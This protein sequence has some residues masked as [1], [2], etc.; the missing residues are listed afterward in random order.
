MSHGY[1]SLAIRS[2]VKTFLRSVDSRYMMWHE[3]EAFEIRIGEQNGRERGL[4]EVSFWEQNPR[5]LFANLLH[6]RLTCGQ[7]TAGFAAPVVALL[8]SPRLHNCR[9]KV[10][11]RLYVI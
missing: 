6:A 5:R 4:R 2:L 3:H 11:E 1:T 9:G 7:E 8:C 10:G